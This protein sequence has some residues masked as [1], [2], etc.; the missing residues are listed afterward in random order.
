MSSIYLK[1]TFSNRLYITDS[2]WFPY[3][4]RLLFQ[5]LVKKKFK[6]KFFHVFS[7]NSTNLR[8]DKSKTHKTNIKRLDS[9]RWEKNC[10]VM[11]SWPFSLPLDSIR[12]VISF[13]FIII[14]TKVPD[15]TR[16]HLITLFCFVMTQTF[17]PSHQI[18]I[19]HCSD[20][21][22]STVTFN[23]IAFEQHS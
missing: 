6:H 23:F 17:H 12:N 5:I 21:S 20:V 1:N 16:H 3:N 2:Q 22:L 13:N 11:L 19:K 10:S 4:G 14:M 15:C 18:I 7:K 8:A 9:C